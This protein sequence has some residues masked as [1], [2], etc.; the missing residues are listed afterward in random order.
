MIER[1]HCVRWQHPDPDVQLRVEIVD[2]PADPPTVVDETL[3]VR[4]Y[5]GP[6]GFTREGGYVRGS[7]MKEGVVS[8]PGN[9]ERVTHGA[10][11]DVPEPATALLFTVGI[12]FL[13]SLRRLR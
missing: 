5:C 6:W 10:L 12:L 7:A 8:Q 4:S 13:L 3:P 9:V 1:W 11:V 2:G